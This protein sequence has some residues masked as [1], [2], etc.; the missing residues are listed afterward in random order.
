MEVEVEVEMEMEMDMCT[1]FHHHFSKYDNVGCHTTNSDIADEKPNEHDYPSSRGQPRSPV[2]ESLPES[3]CFF[4]ASVARS[5]PFLSSSLFLLLRR[6]WLVQPT[7]SSL[8]ASGQRHPYLVAVAR[9]SPLLR[10][11]LPLSL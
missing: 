8:P 4:F 2:V 10:S 5:S 7:D 1:N 9:L 3:T 11:P 6:R